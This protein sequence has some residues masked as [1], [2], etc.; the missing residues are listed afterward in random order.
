MK[1]EYNTEYFL[2]AIFNNSG[3]VFLFLKYIWTKNND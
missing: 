3:F 2:P 1:I